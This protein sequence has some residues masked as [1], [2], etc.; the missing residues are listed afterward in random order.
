M[1]KPATPSRVD[2]IALD[3]DALDLFGK[4]IDVVYSD[5]I[6]RPEGEVLAL[7]VRAL[8]GAS[9]VVKNKRRLV[10]TYALN[11]GAGPFLRLAS[12]EP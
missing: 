7:A 9:R 2:G 3:A 10:P 5:D 6:G 4:L 8:K 1:P 11:G 12:S